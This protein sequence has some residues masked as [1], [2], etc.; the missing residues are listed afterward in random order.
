MNDYLDTLSASRVTITLAGREISIER[1]RLGLHLRLGRLLDDFEEAPGSP[2]MA[3]AIRGYV[4]QAVGVSAFEA[5]GL[6][7]D[8]AHPVE[9]L[10]A[11]AELRALNSWQMS[12]AFMQRSGPP[13][14]PE[15]YDYPGR[16]WASIVAKIASCFGWTEEYI[17][18]MFP[19]QVGIYY[20]EILLLEWRE[21]EFLYN[22][23]EKSTGYD[24]TSKKSYYIPFPGRP[25]WTVDN[26]LPKPVR[27]RVEMLPF[28]VVDLAGN[29]KNYH[30]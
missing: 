7:V 8:Q 29:E 3:E 12:L 28:G 15:I 1:A 13:S 22:L 23:S 9:V 2:E 24:S 26:R 11:F 10:R 5:L 20:Q 17:F 30:H 6:E 27:V 14:P 21:Q 25:A 16:V 18:S 19:E 4:V